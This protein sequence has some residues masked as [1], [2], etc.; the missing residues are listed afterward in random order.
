MNKF[1]TFCAVYRNEAPR[2]RYGLDLAASLFE[3]MLIVV[4]PSDDATLKICQEYTP[5][6]I[7]RKI[8]PPEVSKD[9]IMRHLETPWMF[10][11][12]ADEFPSLAV[13]RMLERI[14]PYELIGKDSV[15]FIRVNYVDGIIIEAQGIDRQYRMLK[16]SVRW[17]CKQ[18][19]Q[20]VHIHPLVKS[21]KESN[22]FIYH[23]RTFDKVKRQT[24]VWN[25]YE[26]KTKDACNQYVK[27]VE[28]E[29]E[30]KGG[31]K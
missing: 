1:I 27:D 6:V 29:L 31:K 14:E 9:I 7:E 20:L 11:L 21:V 10:Y 24:E 3:N 18:Q 28:K 4:Q 19:G 16:K 25:N 5:N 17:N 26:P 22:L 8:E 23:H 2:I 13:I 15:S 12:D 30:V